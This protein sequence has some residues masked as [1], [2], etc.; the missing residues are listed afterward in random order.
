MNKKQ[1]LMLAIAAFSFT[2][3]GC[4]KDQTPENNCVSNNT[5]VPTSDRGS[6]LTDLYHRKQSYSNPAPR[7]VL[8]QDRCPGKWRYTHTGFNSDC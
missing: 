7:W 5:G 2:M 8:L 3:S 4:L 1:F 6:V